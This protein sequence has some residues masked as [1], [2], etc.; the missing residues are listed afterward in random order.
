MQCI[1]PIKAGFDSAGNITYRSSS[2]SKELAPFQFPC[3]K[4]LP[5]R[6][7]IAREKAVRAYHEA[8]MHEDNIFLTL[9]YSDEHLKDPKLNYLDFQ[10]FM[11]RLREKHTRYVTDPDLKKEMHISY[12]VTG[13]YGDEKKRP[14]WHAILFNFRP[15]DAEY[16]YSNELGDKSYESKLITDTWEKGNC[17]FGEVTIESAGYVA[18]YAAK[19]LV[20]GND[21]D[22]DYHPIHKTSSRRAIGRSWIEKYHEQTFNHGYVLLPNGSKTKIPRYYEDWYKKHHFD[23][24]LVYDSTVKKELAERALKNSRKEE[25]ENWS[26]WQNYKGG[27]PYPLS[28][29]KVKETILKLKF[30]RLQEHLKL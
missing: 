3:R 26:N 8:Q 30:K 12:M 21:Q 18:R 4:C 29:S 19:K 20:H 11:K 23:K 28:R 16:K 17:E 6:L 14:H 22:H 1:R 2:F 7:N 25:L 24:W 27:K 13:E 5:C 15:V 10:L 9:T